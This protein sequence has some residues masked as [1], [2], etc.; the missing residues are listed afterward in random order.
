MLPFDNRIGVSAKSMEGAFESIF[1]NSKTTWSFS[2]YC[3]FVHEYTDSI[4]LTIC[5]ISIFYNLE[6]LSIVKY[7]IHQAIRNK[8]V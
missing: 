5:S 3:V 7:F 2:W 6:T 4:A 8:K 1:S